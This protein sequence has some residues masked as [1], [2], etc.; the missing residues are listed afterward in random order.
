MMTRQK[1]AVSEGRQGEGQQEA[2][3]G[4]NQGAE[5]RLALPPCVFRRTQSS[6]KTCDR[7]PAWI[8]KVVGLVNQGSFYPFCC[9]RWSLSRPGAKGHEEQ[10]GRG[11]T[12][13]ACPAWRPFFFTGAGCK[14]T[15]VVF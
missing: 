7:A 9:G 5:E 2:V 13:Q 4:W 1:E 12:C 15:S 3:L 8:Q 10:L 14:V 6:F 11:G